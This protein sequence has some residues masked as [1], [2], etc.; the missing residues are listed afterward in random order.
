M[1]GE[2]IAI[3]MQQNKWG[4][5]ATVGSGVPFIDGFYDV[6]CGGLRERPLGRRR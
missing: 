4:E 3:N 5:A 6:E 2:L 1:A